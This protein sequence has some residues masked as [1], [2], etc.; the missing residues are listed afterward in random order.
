MPRRKTDAVPGPRNP[1]RF[2]VRGR[3]IGAPGA[4]LSDPAIRETSGI[5]EEPWKHPGVFWILSVSGNPA[6]L[7]AIRRDGRVLASFAVAAPNVDWEDIATDDTG[8]LF[9]GD[10]GNNATL[11]P[12]RAIYRID[13]PDPSR[14]SKKPLPVTLATFY[15]FASKSE[16]FDA[17]SL[18]VV[19]SDAFL[20]AKRFDGR[21][22][23]LYALALHPAATLLKPATPRSVGTVPGFTEPATGAALSEDGRRLAVV[24]TRAVR[25]YDRDGRGGLTLRGTVRYKERD[26]EA[27][28]WDGPDLILVTESGL[29]FRLAGGSWTP[30][31]HAPPDVPCPSLL[32]V[33]WSSSAAA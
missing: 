29:L 5:V 11:L 1:P 23:G 22:A 15:R 28:A 18:F 6:A 26:A 21:D 2:G 9:L 3:P 30:S 19:G 20:I 4:K 27:I 32:P 14:P 16:R 31:A 10:I 12:L 13:E 25:V 7:P 33:T 24:S 17:E 8:H